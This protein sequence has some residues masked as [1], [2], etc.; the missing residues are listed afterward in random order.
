MRWYD[1][2]R[3][4]RATEP[5]TAGLRIAAQVVLRWHL[6]CQSPLRRKILHSW[7]GNSKP[8]CLY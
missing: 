3:P 6:G 2:G 1:P 4:F 7:V 8:T 5:W